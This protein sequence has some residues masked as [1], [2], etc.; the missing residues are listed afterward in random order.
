MPENKESDVRYR[1]VVVYRRIKPCFDTEYRKRLLEW[2]RTQ[3]AGQTFSYTVPDGFSSWV[4]VEESNFRRDDESVG[5]P[6]EFVVGH[7][8]T[9]KQVRGNV[10][11]EKKRHANDQTLELITV[12]YEQ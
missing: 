7:Y 1:A 2:A 8:D 6:V 10:T 11:R 5:K 3:D 12:R 4:E 9:I